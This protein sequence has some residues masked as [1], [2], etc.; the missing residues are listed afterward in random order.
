MYKLYERLKLLRKRNNL[1]QNALAKKMGVTRATVNAWEMGIS[2]PN[3]QSLMVLAKFFKVSV[4]YL[5]GN[6]DSDT[7]DI[8]ALN[9]EEK[10]LIY[11]MINYMTSKKAE[12]E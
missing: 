8:S 11:D 10:K 3:A 1:S 6:D 9:D 5:L 4:D 7:I 2:F 12:T